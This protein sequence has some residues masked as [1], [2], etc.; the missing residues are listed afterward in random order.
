MYQTLPQDSPT[1]FW[2]SC[3]IS[4][5]L[6]WERCPAVCLPRRARRPQERP[7]RPCLSPP[8]PC[9]GP[10]LTER[11]P[12]RRKGVKDGERGEGSRNRH[13]AGKQQQ[14]QGNG[15]HPR[16]LPANIVGSLLDGI[17]YLLTRFGTIRRH[18]HTIPTVGKLHGGCRISNGSRP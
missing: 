6:P 17:K 2:R 16:I 10:L 3:R 5:F 13:S 18:S 12:V 7:S 15:F 9:K 8:L 11:T 14:Q 4:P 1:T